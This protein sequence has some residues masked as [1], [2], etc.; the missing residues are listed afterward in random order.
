LGRFLLR[1]IMSV[2]VLIKVGKSRDLR[3]ELDR[4]DV[5]GGRAS[6]CS[7]C[8]KARIGRWSCYKSML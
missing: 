8:R 4:P 6:D 1:N 2:A 5:E 7:R 3:I